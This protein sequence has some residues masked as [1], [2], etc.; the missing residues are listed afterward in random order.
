M[1]RP[2]SEFK[3]RTVNVPGIVK[4]MQNN[5][6]VR[7]KETLTDYTDSEHLQEYLDQDWSTYTGSLDIM[8]MLGF[9]DKDKYNEL[10]DEGY[11]LYRMLTRNKTA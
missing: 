11:N 2:G 6:T 9:I 10:I 1:E 4:E 7:V 5:L 3:T 8:Q